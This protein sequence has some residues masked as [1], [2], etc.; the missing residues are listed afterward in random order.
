M[1]TQPE[2]VFEY[3]KEHGKTNRIV[4]WKELFI[5]DVPKAVSL[6]NHIAPGKGLPQIIGKR[7]RNGTKD[8]WIAL[9]QEEKAQLQHFKF[10]GAVAYT[11]KGPERDCKECQPKQESFL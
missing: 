5:V 4:L 10:D 8:Y 2:Q 1:K 9:S 11:H 6:W 7:T 3:L